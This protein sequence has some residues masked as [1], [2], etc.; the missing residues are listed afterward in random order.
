MTIVE[1][2]PYDY[3]PFQENLYEKRTFKLNF[4]MDFPMLLKISFNLEHPEM[5]PLKNSISHFLY[6]NGT[7]FWASILEERSSTE[8]DYEESKFLDKAFISAYTKND[9]L[10]KN[11]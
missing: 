10:I 11:A 4:D 5:V 3:A 9:L 8:G 6:G 2:I 1:I 7:Q